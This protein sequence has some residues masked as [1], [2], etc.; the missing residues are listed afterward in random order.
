MND[1]TYPERRAEGVNLGESDQVSARYSLDRIPVV[2]AGANKA[3][4][5]CPE[6]A[7]MNCF[8]CPTSNTVQ[9]RRCCRGRSTS[10]AGF[11]S[12]NFH[13]TAHRNAEMR[14]ARV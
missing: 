5:S 4:Y 1:G 11:A 13:R 6:I 3:S 8:A 10:P 2:I 9:G 14:T 7:L 12:S